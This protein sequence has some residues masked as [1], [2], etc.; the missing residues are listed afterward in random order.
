[1]WELIRV[2]KRNSIILMTLMAV[3]LLLL[4][5]II[6]LSFFGPDG[7]FFGLIIATVI[8]LIL[9]AVSFSS[10]DQILLAAS[11]AAPVTHDVHPQLFNVVEEMKIAAAL[12]AMPKIYII[13]DPAPNAFATGRNPQSASVAVTAGL[14]GRLNRDELQGVIAH[15]VSHILH[16]DILFVTLAGIMLGSIVLL[17]Q[18]FLRSMF[19]SSMMGSRRR[20]S[21]GGKDAGQA[22]IIMLVVAIICAILAPIMAYLLYF[23]L[24][25][26]REYLADA[27]AAR[28]TRYPEGLAS[29]LEKI[30]ND[31]SPQLATVNKVTAPMYIVNPFKKKKQ[32]KLSDLTS[33]HPPISERI[34]ILRNMTHGASFADY[35]DSFSKVT[36][37]KT[38]IPPTALTKE[39]VELRQASAEARKKQRIET[40][41]RQVGDIMRRV[42]QFIFLTC[43][44]GLKLKVPPNYK[45]NTV[46]CPRCKRILDVTKK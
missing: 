16:R 46:K 35:S 5:F 15:E 13:N 22:Q 1:M 6:G 28:L 45:A 10:G 31:K 21:S 3:V 7:G 38:V 11:K 26:R 17:S 25:R 37:T 24:S 14:L 30:A 9:T 41:M 23:A 4:G 19:Y 36:K 40:Q 12:P 29:A 34:K 20:Y 8:W 2:N 44:C 32:M 33:T 43:L 27:G 42:N 39:A 18:V